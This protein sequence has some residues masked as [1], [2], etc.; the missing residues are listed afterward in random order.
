MEVDGGQHYG[1]EGMEKDE[2]RKEFI[3]ALSIKV[4]RFSNLEVLHNT[5]AV[6]TVIWE[7][8]DNAS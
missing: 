8:V 6:L 7:A 5:E 4:L 2:Q 3:E 1:K